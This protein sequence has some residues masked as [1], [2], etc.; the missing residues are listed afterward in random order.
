M[1]VR[2]ILIQNIMLKRNSNHS[3]LKCPANGWAVQ[4]A[5]FSKLP[6]SAWSRSSTSA[7]EHISKMI[8]R[9]R[10]G[11]PSKKVYNLPGRG[12]RVSLL[13]RRFGPTTRRKIQC[14]SPI[15]KLGTLI[16]TLMISYPGPSSG[17]ERK[18]AD[19]VVAIFQA[20][21]S[22]K[23]YTEKKTGSVTLI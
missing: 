20:N 13:L 16:I 8:V 11:Q 21:R 4:L 1:N 22:L 14:K 5:Q 3:S 7:A 17:Q 6:Y 10:I 2:Y 19:N 23:F 9:E 12:L 15:P 18:S